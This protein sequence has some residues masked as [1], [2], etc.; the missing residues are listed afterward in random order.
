[1]SAG[2]VGLYRRRV[3]V[4]LEDGTERLGA[5]EACVG[6]PP[7]R[8]HAALE[9]CRRGSD[10]HHYL[11]PIVKANAD[12]RRQVPLPEHLLDGKPAQV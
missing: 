12:D 10:L 9:T 2:H 3:L 8:F 4:E 6:K 5:G 11:T 1:M 7:L